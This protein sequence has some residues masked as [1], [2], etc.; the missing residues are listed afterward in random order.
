MKIEKINKDNIKEY[1]RDM[2]IDI[3]YVDEKQLINNTFGVKKDNKFLFGFVSLSEEGL[4]SITFGDNKV[5]LN[6]TKDLDAIPRAVCFCNEGYESELS[7]GISYEDIPG[8]DDSYLDPDW[9]TTINDKGDDESY[10]SEFFT[11]LQY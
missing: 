6:F 3:T 9:V 11:R 7:I 1:I 4:I 8:R 5:E 2:G 10:P